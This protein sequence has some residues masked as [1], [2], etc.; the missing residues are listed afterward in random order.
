M[1]DNTYIILSWSIMI[2][3]SSL[4][5]IRRTSAIRV[6]FFQVYD[7]IICSSMCGSHLVDVLE[8]KGFGVHDRHH[9]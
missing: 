5:L 4:E 9:T 6:I 3:L 2:L 7:T 8:G 1:V